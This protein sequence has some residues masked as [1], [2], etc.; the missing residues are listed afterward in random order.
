MRRL[1]ML[2]VLTI[3]VV[4]SFSQKAELVWEE[5]M[6]GSP[7]LI[8]CDKEGSFYA[9]GWDSE[10][11]SK[12]IEKYDQNKKLIVSKKFEKPK[13]NGVEIGIDEFFFIEN[14]IIAFASVVGKIDVDGKK[15]KKHTAYSCIINL[16]GT[17]DNS[18]IKKVGQVDVINGYYRGYFKYSISDDKSKLLV[19]GTRAYQSSVKKYRNAKKYYACYDDELNLIWEKEIEFPFKGG[20]F[21]TENRVIGNDG[22]LATVATVKSEKGKKVKDYTV[23]QYNG[24]KDKLNEI[25]IKFND[26]WPTSAAIYIDNNRK[27]L[28]VSGYYS[29]E[30]NMDNVVKGFYTTQINFID[31]MVKNQHLQDLSQDLWQSMRSELVAKNTIIDNNTKG[32]RHLKVE[33]YFPTV[34]DGGYFVSSVNYVRDLTINVHGHILVIKCN[35]TGEVEWMKKVQQFSWAE[36]VKNNRLGYIAHYIQKNKE[37]N[38]ILNDGPNTDESLNLISIDSSGN[39]TI[40]EL[41]K[42]VNRKQFNLVFFPANHIRMSDESIIIY[43][44][45]ELHQ[46]RKTEFKFGEIKFE[47]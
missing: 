37:V 12:T 31:G 30:G 8:G 29:E 11:K 47:K 6:N 18:S 39:K 19:D 5:K 17:I 14:K 7:E 20:D 10:K 2:A 43:A 16:D 28:V 27:E 13:V 34:D 42:E 9:L 45:S 15:Q 4:S 1:T 33:H 26:K 44:E 36:G 46:L 32:L 22:N 38:I 25:K 3:I 21:I 23:Y 41:F 40:T 35:N 24:V